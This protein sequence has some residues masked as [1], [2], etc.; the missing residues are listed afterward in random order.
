MEG[1]LIL[2]RRARPFVFAEHVDFR[3][4]VPTS[5][6]LYGCGMCVHAR[7]FRHIVPTWVGHAYKCASL[8]RRS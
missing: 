3:R 6:W 7:F 2:A 5:A 8:T 4:R 1:V